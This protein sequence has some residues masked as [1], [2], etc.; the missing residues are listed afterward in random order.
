MAVVAMGGRQS[1]SMLTVAGVTDWIAT[2]ADEYVAQVARHAAN[3]ANLAALRKR[4]SQSPLFDAGR[5][6]GHFEAALRGMW[7]HHCDQPLA[8]LA[9]PQSDCAPFCA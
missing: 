6:G 2:S 5:F 1:A 3:S 4:V 7:Q 9:K 8:S